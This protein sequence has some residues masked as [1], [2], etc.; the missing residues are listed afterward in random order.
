MAVDPT[1]SYYEG[2]SLGS[3]SGTSAVA[4][5]PRI[6]RALLSVGGGTAFDIFTTSPAFHAGTG[7]LLASLIPGFTWEAIDSTNAAFN[8]AIAADYLKTSIL[9]KWILDPGDPINYASA[10]VAAPMANFIADKTFQTPQAAK[11]VQ[12]Q[13]A[14]LDQV[15]PNTTNWLLYQLMAVP[16]SLYVSGTGDG[17]VPHGMLGTIATVQADAAGFL[18]SG[19]ATAATINLP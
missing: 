2:I 5:N 13:V 11:T 3:I 19:T 7:A 1:T 12:A 15:V 14:A 17:R 18:L 9:A 6:S 4:A 10:M 16:T 8:P